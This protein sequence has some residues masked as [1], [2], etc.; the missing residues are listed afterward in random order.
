MDFTTVF[1]TDILPILV[2]A[3]GVGY[4]IIIDFR[5]LEQQVGTNK[6][7]VEEW[8]QDI[9]ADIGGIGDKVD[10]LTKSV[11]K[12][13]GDF[14]ENQAKDEARDERLR[15]LEKAIVPRAEHEAKWAAFEQ[16]LSFL[17]K[18]LER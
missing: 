5:K 11:N 10:D 1:L 8:I 18:H 14:R 4:K 12:I 7:A 15:T 9:R 13:E 6:D 16:R 17:E 2:G 3:G